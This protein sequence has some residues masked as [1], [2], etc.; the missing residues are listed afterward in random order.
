MLP[1]LGAFA[2]VG[3]QNA[4]LKARSGQLG[5]QND[6]PAGRQSVLRV[7]ERVHGAGGGIRTPTVLLPADFESAASSIPPLRHEVGLLYRR[8]LGFRQ[9]RVNAPA[10][11]MSFVKHKTQGRRV[12]CHFGTRC[13]VSFQKQPKRG[14]FTCWGLTKCP[15]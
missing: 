13:Y 4:L 9:Y 14:Y 15:F 12:G 5:G 11:R 6:E 7:W 3:G 10:A 1:V 2:P 8:I